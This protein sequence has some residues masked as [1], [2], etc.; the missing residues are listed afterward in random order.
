MNNL[1]AIVS[2]IK[3]S[4]SACHL[5]IA[6]ALDMLPGVVLDTLIALSHKNRVRPSIMG[7]WHLLEGAQ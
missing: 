7:D 6:K 4:G 1:D 2:Y 3:S 5:D